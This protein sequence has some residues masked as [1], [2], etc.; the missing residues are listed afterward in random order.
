LERVLTLLVLHGALGGLDVLLNHEIAE[1]LPHRQGAGREEALHAAREA[2]FATLFLGLAWF[3]W[4]GAAAWFIAAVIA[5]EVTVST[6]DS[7]LEDQTR[8]LP[9][10]ERVLHTALLI[11]LGAYITLL[12]P[13]WL[14]WRA[15]PTAV[16][17]AWHGWQTVALSAL[18]MA[19]AA[20]CVRDALC[21]RRLRALPADA[22]PGL[23]AQR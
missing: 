8:R 4:R 20:W 6:W 21:S 14:A 17:P 3:E 7:V 2:L 19:A 10:L 18:G 13:H 11:N 15:L 9:P 22:G 23:A 5:C 16:T 1:R 12:A